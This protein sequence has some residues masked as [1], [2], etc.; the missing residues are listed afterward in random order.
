M[1]VGKKVRRYVIYWRRGSQNDE[2]RADEQESIRDW[3]AGRRREHRTVEV[4]DDPHTPWD[5]VLAGC[6]AF[7]SDRI[8]VLVAGPIEREMASRLRNLGLVPWNLVLDFDPDSADFGLGAATHETLRQMRALHEV[9]LGDRPSIRVEGSCYWYYARGLSRRPNTVSD[10]G[11]MKWKQKYGLDLQ[12]QLR[13]LA[14][15]RGSRPVTVIATW[16]AEDFIDTVLSAAIDVFGEAVDFVIPHPNAQRL[17][18]LADRYAASLINID[19][20]HIGEGVG[21][22]LRDTEGRG[23]DDLRLPSKSGV[24][25]SVNPEDRRYLEEDL[26]LVGLTAGTVADRD[27]ETCLAFFRG[28]QITWFECGLHCDVDRDKADRILKAVRQD[29]GGGPDRRSRG[30]TRINLYHAPGAGGS[31]VGRRILWQLH[32]EFPCV[33]VHRAVPAETAERLQLVYRLTGLPLL[34]LIEGADVQENQADDLYSILRARQ[35]SAVL[36]QVLRRFS[37][38]EERERSFYLESQLSHIEATRFAH[39]LGEARPDRRARLVSLAS[40]GSP[41]ERTAFLG[42]HRKTGH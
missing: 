34:V 23:D 32:S 31:T 42:G 8:Y 2:A 20:H 28:K 27:R 36:L 39:R 38:V 12:E 25:V 15:A 22:I 35:V 18:R 16:D 24:S 37:G 21:N 6:H 3:C 33:V 17:T 5:R 10:P 9:T 14:A 1:D 29:L 40:D 26:E 4:P 13:C 30:T 19:L 11:W 41:K 7:E